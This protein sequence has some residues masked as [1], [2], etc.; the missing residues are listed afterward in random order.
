MRPSACRTCRTLPV[1]FDAEGNANPECSWVFQ[2]EGEATPQWDGEPM[3]V[4]SG[5]LWTLTPRGNWRPIGI[6]DKR[7]CEA[8]A[9]LKG[10]GVPPDGGYELCG[11]GIAGNPH[12]FSRSVLVRHMGVVVSNLPALT[13]DA[14]S[15]WLLAAK[16]K[17]L[18]W[19]HA[20][21]RKAKL[22][23]ADVGLQWP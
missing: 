18:V 14:L 10:N 3:L 9:L 17:G 20:D 7:A 13:R 4:M 6:Q 2:G 11:P 5:D 22:R 12:G 19:H 15:Q 1:I 21:G 23:R 8:W 16:H